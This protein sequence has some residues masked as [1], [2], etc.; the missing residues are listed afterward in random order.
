VSSNTTSRETSTRH[1]RS[2]HG[3]S[4]TRQPYR[5]SEWTLTITSRNTES[6]Q[7]RQRDLQQRAPCN[8]HQGLRPIISERPQRVPSPAARTM[9]FISAPIIDG[10]FTC[11]SS[12]T[13]DAAPLPQAHFFARKRFANCSAR[14]TDRC[15]PPLQPNAPSIF[16]PAFLVIPTLASTSDST[17]AKNWCTLSC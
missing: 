6:A 16:E 5:R 17:L 3:P 14:N 11:P 4:N 7:T 2:C 13:P 10:A 12:P 9:A 15:C 1:F 8:L